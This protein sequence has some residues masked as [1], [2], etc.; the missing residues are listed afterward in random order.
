MAS[1]N[2]VQLIGNLGK[3]PEVRHT[4]SGDAVAN[5][6]IATSE[7]WKDKNSGEKKEATEWH[8]V[9]VWGRLAEICEK[10]LA[11]GSKVFVE[12]T[13][14]TEKWVDKDGRDRYTTKVV[15]R[16]FDA[17]LIMLGDPK[18]NG[19]GSQHRDDDEGDTPNRGGTGRAPGKRS[20]LDDEIPFAPE[21][22]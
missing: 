18:G 4:Q 16:G 11:K 6:S 22:R 21:F 14:R 20:D 9:V 17:K 12:G 19:G 13:L 3:N 1:L 5:F 2:K 15:L 7:S 10:Y 8:T